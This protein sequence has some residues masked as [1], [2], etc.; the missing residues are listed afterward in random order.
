VL[1][2]LSLE[3]LFDVL[4]E[5]SLKL[6]IEVLELD[7]LKLLMLSVNSSQFSYL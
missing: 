3:E 4:E 2:E 1:E 7:S 6:L 5:L